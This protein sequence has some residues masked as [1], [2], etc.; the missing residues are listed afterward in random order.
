MYLTHPSVA[1]SAIQQFLWSVG[2]KLY[3]KETLPIGLLPAYDLARH[4]APDS[5]RTIFD[6]GANIGQTAVHFATHF[7]QANIYSFEPV[8][9]TFQQLKKHT[10]DYPNVQCIQLALSDVA[11]EQVMYLQEHSWLNSLSEKVNQK[12]SNTQ[13]V[14]LHTLDNFCAEKGITKIDLLKID[15]EGYDMHV[16]RGAEKMLRNKNIRYLLIEV[17][18]QEQDTQHSQFDEISQHLKGFGFSIRGFYNQF[19]EYGKP[20]GYVDALFGLA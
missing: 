16:L 1:K 8:A 10:A 9:Q 13:T 5:P 20:L 3:K 18:F 19:V 2:I 17:G 11:G 4:F 15:T 14:Q 12:N 7:K 6:V